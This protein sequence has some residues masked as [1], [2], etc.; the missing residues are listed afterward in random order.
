[1][2]NYQEIVNLFELA[3]GENEFFK[4]FGH[5]SIDNL[6][7]VVNR[8]YPLLFMRPLSSAGLSGQDGRV[9]S[10]TFE[11]YSLDVPKISDANSKLT[12]KSSKNP[13]SFGF[14]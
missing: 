13:H 8:G 14:L 7:A 12:Y 2:I 9:R 4:G 1:M 11:L 6:D 5:G 10:L 3:V